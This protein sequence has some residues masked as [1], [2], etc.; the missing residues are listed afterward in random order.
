MGR[1]SCALLSA[2]GDPSG[3]VNI[4]R[5]HAV[6]AD[7]KC[8][9]NAGVGSWDS[10]RLSA[11]LGDALTPDGRVRAR[12]VGRYE[13]GKSYI[14]IQ[15]RKKWVLY[16]V[17]EADVTDSTLVRT[18]ISHQDT[19]PSGATWGARSD[20]HTSELQSLMPLSYALFCL[21]K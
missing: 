9:R 13:R 20:D 14:D 3:S 18:G 1:R 7:F 4:V 16:G 19:K 2:L 5:K 21:I 8:Y 17:V 15:D 10:C 12:V 11:D 6:F